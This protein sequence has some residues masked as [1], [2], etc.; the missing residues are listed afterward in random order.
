[1]RTLAC[2]TTLHGVTNDRF[3]E[4]ARS[5]DQPGE[6]Q[7]WAELVLL[8]LK[9]TD[10]PHHGLT[11][12]EASLPPRCDPIQR[13]AE[14]PVDLGQGNRIGGLQLRPQAFAPRFPLT[15]PLPNPCAAA[16]CVTT[17]CGTEGG[18][19]QGTADAG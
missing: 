5:D 6:R 14:G 16:R 8:C 12:P 4:A 9:R 7:Q 10:A 1:M 18:T 2:S 19:K 11:A 17:V 3:W 15:N 13:G